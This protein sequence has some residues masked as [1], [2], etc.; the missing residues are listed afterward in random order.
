MKL[1]L[2]AGNV[3]LLALYFATI[4]CMFNPR[5]SQEYHE[6]YISK[7]SNLSLA[8]E[9]QLNSNPIQASKEYD[10][11]SAQLGFSAGWSQADNAAYRTSGNFSRIIFYINEG[12]YIFK[13]TLLLDISAP[14]TQ[15]LEVFMNGSKVHSKIL[16]AGREKISIDFSPSL[17]KKG[18]NMIELHTPDASQS[19]NGARRR[20][21]LALNSLEFR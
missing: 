2:R 15:P 13:G 5:V 3:T 9:K 20:P 16:E 4:Y 12:N 11:G 19:G 1:F 18:R 10:H 21:D 14:S 17:L 6:Y 7:T 8:A